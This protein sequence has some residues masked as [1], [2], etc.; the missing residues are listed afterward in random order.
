[1]YL[2]FELVYR[3]FAGVDPA[4]ETEPSLVR[5]RENL[6][7][8]FIATIAAELRSDSQS[9]V[10]TGGV[11]ATLRQLA[12][13]DSGPSLSRWILQ[14]GDSQQLREF[15]IHRSAYQLKE[16]DQHTAA[17]S[18]L[19]SGRA[20]SAFIKIQTDE[21]GYGEPYQTHQELFAT[22]LRSLDLKE[23][24][25][26]YLDWIPAV[27]LATVNLLSIF[28]SSRRW[29]GACI[30]HLALFEM[31]S[32]VPMSRYAMAL[33][34]MGN[35]PRGSRF[36]EIHVEA[37]A[38][39]EV[40]ALHDMV[41]PLL[42]QMPHLGPDVVFGARALTLVERWFAQHLIDSWEAGRTSLHQQLPVESYRG[43]RQRNVGEAAPI[44]AGRTP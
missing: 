39:H 5:I 22:T 24:Y 17:I 25:G 38:V 1:M 9:E 3:G 27:T 16:V 30:G 19:P 37:D 10:T 31:I 2:C 33:Q 35:D 4:W 6:A 42:E 41:G 26:A 12:E 29:L 43:A 11:V 32:S 13:D 14:R 44:L 36:Y 21:Y 18:R 7:R 28:G 20:K 8:R 23:S 40:I 34:R 15:V